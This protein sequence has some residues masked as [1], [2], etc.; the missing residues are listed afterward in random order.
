MAQNGNSLQI[1]ELRESWVTLL[2]V[3]VN[4]TESEVGVGLELPAVIS[5][6]GWLCNRDAAVCR[7]AG[8]GGDGGGRGS[9]A[10]LSFRPFVFT[11]RTCSLYHHKSTSFLKRW[12]SNSHRWFVSKQLGQQSWSTEYRKG[13]AEG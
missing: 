2:S 3:F 10:C 1:E 5:S 13:Q 9:C 4:V 7:S 11:Q 12:S 8:R 6:T